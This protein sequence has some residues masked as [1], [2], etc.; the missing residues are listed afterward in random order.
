MSL[1]NLRHLFEPERILWVGPEGEPAGWARIA[2]ANLWD[3]GFKGSIQALRSTGR[4]PA[5]ARI[6]TLA[7]LPAEPRLAAVVLPQTDLPLLL[8]ELADCGC[9][10]VA[11]VGGGTGAAAL[12][13]EQAAAAR[14]AAQTLGLRLT[15]PDRVGVI[16]PGRRL[17][18]GSA[19]A[20]PPPG[21]LA[22]VTQSDSI[23]TAMLEWASAERIGFSCIASLGEFAEIELGDILDYLALDPATRAILIHLEGIADARRFMSAAR[24]AARIKPVLVLKAGRCIGQSAD[25]PGGSGPRLNRDRVYDAAFARAGLVRVESIGGAVRRGGQPGAGCPA[26]R[27]RPAP[28]PAR[29]LDQ[30]PRAGRARGR[31]FAARWGGLGAP[32]AADP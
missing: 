10:A 29:H 27:P 8:R 30:R 21:D 22:F 19:A 31:R 7:G 25:L 26:P 24:A 2:E 6:E 17:N 18:T 15:G 20:M 5:E 4:A 11:L 23:A 32:D 14:S 9:R 1:R 12:D 13:G 28:G 16:V 3:A